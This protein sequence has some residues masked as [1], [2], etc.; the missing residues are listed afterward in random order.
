MAEPSLGD[1]RCHLI[2]SSWISPSHPIPSGNHSL[3]L[4]QHLSLDWVTPQPQLAASLDA[5]EVPGD[6]P[7]LPPPRPAPPGLELSKSCQVGLGSL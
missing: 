4:T 3:A 1:I 5:T 6:F 7:G 2:S